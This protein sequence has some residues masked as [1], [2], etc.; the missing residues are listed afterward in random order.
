MHNSVSLPDNSD[1]RSNTI[2]ANRQTSL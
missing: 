1:I 2:R